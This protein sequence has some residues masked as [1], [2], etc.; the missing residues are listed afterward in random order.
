MDGRSDISHL[1]KLGEGEL[2]IKINNGIKCCVEARLVRDEGVRQKT[3]SLARSTERQIEAQGMSDF[4]NS[5][6]GRRSRKTYM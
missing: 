2:L 3:G 6:G 5:L 4:V 1:N